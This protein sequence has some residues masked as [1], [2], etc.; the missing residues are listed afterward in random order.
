ML[1]YLELHTLHLLSKV[2]LVTN[3]CRFLDLNVIHLCTC[4]S[5]LW[6]LIRESRII[7]M[8]SKR[9]LCFTRHIFYKFVLQ[10]IEF[11]PWYLLPIDIDSLLCHVIT[12]YFIVKGIYQCTP[13]R[14]D[15]VYSFDSISAPKFYRRYKIIWKNNRL[16]CSL[17][18]TMHNP[19]QTQHVLSNYLSAQA[20]KLWIDFWY[21]WMKV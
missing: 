6:I 15:V 21:T 20:Q 4:F 5:L 17:N 12:F 16:R 7:L 8:K 11:N 10:L 13:G 18:N 3:L 2:A 14:C 9:V 19:C 1:D